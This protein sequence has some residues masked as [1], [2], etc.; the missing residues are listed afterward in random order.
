MKNVVVVAPHPDDET[1]GCGGTL[2]RHI[3]NGDLLHWVIVTE[4]VNLPG[5]TI[6]RNVKR[7]REIQLV[8]DKYGFRGIHTLGLPAA[9]LTPEM[10]PSIIEKIGSLFRELCPEV[11]YAPYPGD[12][13]SDHKI[14]F[15]AVA[16]CSKWFRYPSVKRFML[17]ETLSETEFGFNPDLNGFRPN[18]FVDIAEQLDRKC[19]IA[20]LFENEFHEFPFPRS[21]EA[22]HALAKFRGTSSGF[23]AAESFM[24]LREVWVP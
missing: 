6:E 3:A 22:I 7:D 24:L 18:V 17:Y 23:E 21:V 19:E 5:W 10:L 1:L 11:V 20:L 9:R 8:A 14:V 16:A 4:A 15:D 2:I 13:H 12:A